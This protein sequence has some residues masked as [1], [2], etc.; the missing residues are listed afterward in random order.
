MDF[1]GA[2]K[3]V[4]QKQRAVAEL[5]KDEVSGRVR[6]ID[7]GDPEPAL[8][9]KTGSHHKRREA[10]ILCYCISQAAQALASGNPVARLYAS[11]THARDT[12]GSRLPIAL[13]QSSAVINCLCIKL[14]RR[15]QVR[16]ASERQIAA[17]SV[18]VLVI[19]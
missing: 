3:Y 13:E 6:N 11:S 15:V 10:T 12:Q 8:S 16:A 2:V 4:Q 18:S 9:P 17:A 19:A 14:L 7:C 5:N 1:E